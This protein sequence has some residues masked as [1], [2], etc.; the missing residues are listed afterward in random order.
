MT[1]NNVYIEGTVW[2]AYTFKQ[3]VDPTDELSSD[4]AEVAERYY[5]DGLLLDVID[6]HDFDDGV[7]YVTED[8]R[9]LG[10]G[11][12]AEAYRREE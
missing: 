2:V 11:N 8:G 6:T 9:V 1:T 7:E 4:A 5:E 3:R 12:A 10:D